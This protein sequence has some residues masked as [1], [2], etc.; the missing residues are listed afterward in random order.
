MT[1]N[2]SDGFDPRAQLAA[3]IASDPPPARQSVASDLI[4]RALSEP[5][6]HRTKVEQWVEDGS[7]E[8]GRW[9]EVEA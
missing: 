9:V 2:E 8:G 7:R 6:V 4:D 1:A 5:R 3:I